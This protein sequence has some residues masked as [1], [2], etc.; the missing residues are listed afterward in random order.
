MTESTNP[1]LIPIPE[2]IRGSIRRLMREASFSQEH[3]QLIGSGMLIEIERRSQE[4]DRELWAFLIAKV[5]EIQSFEERSIDP[6]AMIIHELNG[7]KSTGKTIEIPSEYHEEIRL[8]L[9]ERDIIT[10]S[11][12]LV[13]GA[14]MGMM[15]RVRR[16]SA[17]IDRLM[18]L[19]IPECANGTWQ[20]DPSRM[21]AVEGLPPELAADNV[22]QINDESPE[23]N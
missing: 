7:E 5:P 17:Q 16:A 10:N 23:A 1:R 22:D 4:V 18:R 13:G 21:V 14:L 11:S 8:L 6:V 19:H 9:D 3:M 12:T 15:E 20:I 2:N